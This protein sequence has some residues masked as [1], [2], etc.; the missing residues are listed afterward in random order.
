MLVKG[1]LID[2][3]EK[4]ITEVQH[5][6][7]DYKEI[8]KLIDCEPSPFTIVH[9]GDGRDVIFVDDEGLFK[10]PRYFFTIA[11]YPQPIAGKGLV[12]GG[13]EE[14]ET[15]SAEITLEDL[16][17]V[18]GFTELSLKGFKQYSGTMDHPFMGKDTPV[19]GQVPIFEPPDEKQKH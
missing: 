5:D 11:G 9:I 4:T 16:K 8:Y 7:A 6:T 10:D 15:I 13:N 12:L 18:I 2:P 17:K 14:G 3:K 19:F 1:L